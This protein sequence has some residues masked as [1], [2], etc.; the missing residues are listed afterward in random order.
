MSQT[1]PAHTR[2]AIITELACISA[3]LADMQ[4]RNAEIATRVSRV[5]R[6][7]SCTTA[8]VPPGADLQQLR[9]RLGAVRGRLEAT[10]GEIKTSAERIS[11]AAQAAPPPLVPPLAQNEGKPEHARTA[12]DDVSAE[13][14]GKGH[15]AGQSREFVTSAGAGGASA[16]SADTAPVADAPRVPRREPEVRNAGGGLVQDGGSLK[17]AAATV[18]KAPLVRDVILDAYATT[19][20]TIAEIA[21][22]SGSTRD[23][24]KVTLNKARHKDE[25]RIKAG[26]ELR[27][28]KTES[29]L[30]TVAQPNARDVADAAKPD[31][32][33][34]QPRP[35]PTGGIEIPAGKLIA[36]RGAEVHGPTGIWRT[37]KETAKAFSMLAD[38]QL[39]GLETMARHGGLTPSVCV[40]LIAMWTAALAKIGIELH[41]HKGYGL[42]LRAIGGQS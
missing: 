30:A 9:Q 14:R 20:K 39:Y 31:A 16:A 35:I 33:V 4:V 1:E 37:S 38:G 34:P 24:V 18:E 21:V 32:E 12:L 6:D 15:T 28:P 3:E 29:T 19:T 23:S 17:P 13:D 10:A 22:H 25:P 7:L 42:R 40:N 36:V 27:A 41:H 11:P 2:S 8:P 5:I 26:D